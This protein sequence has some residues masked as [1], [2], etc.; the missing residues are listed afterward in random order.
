MVRR[1]KRKSSEIFRFSRGQHKGPGALHFVQ[2][3][4]QCDGR[5]LKVRGQE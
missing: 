1:G 3:M 5:Q 2:M 4:Q